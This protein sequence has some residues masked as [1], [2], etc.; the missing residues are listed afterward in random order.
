MSRDS[1]KRTEVGLSAKGLLNV[2]RNV[3]EDDFTFIVGDSHYKCPSMF[4][5]FLSRRIGSLQSIDPTIRE[6][7]I[8]TT[9]PHKY[10]SKLLLF[11]QV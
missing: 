2:P 4:A 11:V 10:F 8:S 3:Y 5:A 1:S 7:Q 9:D 6:Y